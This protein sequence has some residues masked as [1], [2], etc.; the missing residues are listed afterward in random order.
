M[1][2][3][4]GRAFVLPSPIYHPGVRVTQVACGNEH[5]LLLTE[6]GQVFS[7]GIGRYEGVL[8]CKDCLVQSQEATVLLA[9]GLVHLAGC[10]FSRGQLGHGGLENEQEIARQVDSLAGL[11]VMLVAAGGWHSSAV[12]ECSDLYTWGWNQSGQL[13]FCMGKVI[14]FHCLNS[15]HSQDVKLSQWQKIF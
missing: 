8:W 6:T 12:T 3:V 14:Q 9:H 1:A 7:W 15:K 13:G 2:C 4:A 5:C 10:C 11:R